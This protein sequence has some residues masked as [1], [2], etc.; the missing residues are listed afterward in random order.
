MPVSRKRC[1]VPGIELDGARGQAQS[2][3]GIT[4]AVRR[5]ALPDIDAVPA[6]GPGRRHRIA[7]VLGHRLLQELERLGES[8]LVEGIYDV[9]RAQQMVVGGKA[10][11]SLAQ[12]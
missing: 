4:G 12:R 6:R 7:R 9:E 11:R 8:V 5:P 2:F 10:L 3:F 1:G